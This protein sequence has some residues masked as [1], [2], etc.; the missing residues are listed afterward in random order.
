MSEVESDSFTSQ[1]ATASGGETQHVKAG[2]IKFEK[3]E[4]EGGGEPFGDR[5][6]IHSP[7]QS[8]KGELPQLWELFWV[9]TKPRFKKEGVVRRGIESSKLLEERSLFEKCITLQ[10]ERGASTTVGAEAAAALATNLVVRNGW[11]SN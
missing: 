8:L 4:G 2:A 1:I 7:A 11:W 5:T 3:G 6:T 9:D 10:G